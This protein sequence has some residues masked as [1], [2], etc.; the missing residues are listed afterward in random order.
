M[1]TRGRP[2]AEKRKVGPVQL[3]I[4][5]S[6]ITFLSA[7]EAEQ[8]TE[9]DSDRPRLD[10]E[11][12]ALFVVRLVALSGGQAEVLPV[13]V[14]GEA[15]KV[16]QGTPVR[17]VGLSATPWQM[18]ERSGITYRAE[19]IEAVAPARVAPGAQAS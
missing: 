15:P 19:R 14:A 2:T 3:N 13:R 1:A 12:K 4:D 16:G 8:M 6:S 18:G 17:C 10:K 9:H 11:G 5:T 7:G